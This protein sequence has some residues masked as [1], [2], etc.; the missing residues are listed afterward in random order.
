M[1]N[2]SQP[3][4]STDIADQQKSTANTRTWMPKGA[5]NATPLCWTKDDWAFVPLGLDPTV[6][7]HTAN[8]TGINGDASLGLVR[9]LTVNTPAIRARLECMP[10]DLSNTSA[11]LNTLNFTSKTAWVGA[12][13][14]G[15][16]TGYELKLGLTTPEAYLNPSTS[17]NKDG[18]PIY[19]NFFGALLQL[20]CCATQT[21]ESLGEASMGHWSS[22]S[23]STSNIVVKWIICHPY[24]NKIQDRSLTGPGLPF[25]WVW[26]NIPKVTAMECTP[27][28]E[29]ADASVAIDFDTQT[30]QDFT[31]MHDPIVGE[32]AWKHYYQLLNVS[33]GDNY[34]YFKSAGAELLGGYYVGNITV[35]T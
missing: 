25:H 35:G 12:T 18:S 2:K 3:S 26:K 23:N 17:V 30:I 24:A 22:T 34:T 32:D 20:I 29:S 16:D 31:V 13:P 11:W 33:T 15:S 4:K 27:V 14:P 21:N 1:F 19:T 9:N 28:I 10:L 7:P 8:R 5:Y 6:I